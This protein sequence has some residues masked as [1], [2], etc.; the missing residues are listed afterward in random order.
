STWSTSDPLPARENYQPEGVQE[1]RLTRAQRR[2][3]L[4][5]RLATEEEPQ[6]PQ[7]KPPSL[8]R[9]TWQNWQRW[10]T[11]WQFWVAVMVTIPGGVALIA[12]ASLFRLS[13]QPNCLS[14]F[15]P[16]ASASDRLYC[17]EVTAQKQTV[18][19]L[20]SAIDLVNDLPQDHP[21]RAEINRQ[22]EKWSQDILKLGD[23]AF[24]G[25]NLA[26]AIAIA[27][28]V[29]SDVPAYPQVEKQ[30]QQWQ[31]IWDSADKIY[32]AAEEYL[33]KE[34]WNQAF[35]QATLLLDIGNIY[36]ETTKYEEITKAIQTSRADGNKLAKARSK[37]EAGGVD[38]LLAAMQLAEAIAPN[39]YLYQ[40]A[41][42]AIGE[43]GKKIME[44]AET[45]LK[46][47]QWQE[48]ID[49]VNKIPESAKLKEEVKDFT[50]LARA[51]SQ[52]TAGTVAGL[53]N[54]IK[55]A[56]KLKP[57][58]PL[59]NK[60]QEFI[61]YWQQEIADVKTLEAARQLAAKGGE[62][63]LKAAIAQLQTIPQSNPRG[64]EAKKEIESWTRQVE[65][66]EDTPI[67]ERAQQLA[68]LGDANSL[69]AAIVEA[70]KITSGRALYQQ[71]QEQIKTW[72]EQTQRFRDRPY[73]EQA[74]QLANDGN[75]G[76]AIAAANKIQPG[77]T[78]YEEARS[79]IRNWESQL[80]AK[81]SLDNA[82]QA[83][84]PGTA[85]A[86]E[87]AILLANQ[88]PES[89]GLR[90]QAEEAIDN[91]SQQILAIG[92]SLS[93]SDLRGAIA[94][95]RK[96]PSGT[97]VYEEA[98]SQIQAWEESLYSPPVEPQPSVPK[99]TRSKFPQG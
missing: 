72:A 25:G 64:P 32:Q 59:Y 31:S 83:A 15:L 19:D 35:R 88:V 71:A 33:R 48:A 47:G 74:K 91:W 70:R 36:W 66:M 73:L 85:D 40:A 86:L 26:E 60:T 78:L 28:K 43:F 65:L 12:I 27:R 13:A 84:Q 2:K 63:D 81:D 21:L 9:K 56:K 96:I 24:Q 95:L 16:T 98:R 38:N 76:A 49:I 61:T 97:R 17:A 52:T 90:S 34:D 50:E 77:R 69:E 79:N 41:Q 82:R 22:I 62:N 8:A 1:G 20:L 89:S 6:P 23:A 55:A 45:R 99:N 39:S 30:I 42:K 57:N 75:L 7:Q 87:T 58:R 18:E 53:E 14:I 46:A 80:E 4:A 11:K 29:P 93:A 44:L 3:A 54:A 68:T 5:V 37:A 51:A 67:L 92:Q 10:P 94:I